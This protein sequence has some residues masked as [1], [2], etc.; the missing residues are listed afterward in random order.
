MIEITLRYGWWCNP[1]PQYAIND[2]NILCSDSRKFKPYY[3]ADYAN[4]AHSLDL[5]YLYLDPMYSDPP[6]QENPIN[7]HTVYVNS[8][9]L[10]ITAFIAWNHVKH[11]HI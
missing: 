7:R 4:L 3:K 9:E 8:T 11:R 5:G 10:A 1:I 6:F 2:G